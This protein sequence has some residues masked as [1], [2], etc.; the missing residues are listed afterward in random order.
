MA[1]KTRGARPRNSR[2]MV[3]WKIL[4]MRRKE[5]VKMIVEK[6]V[7]VKLDDAERR[8]LTEKVK[9]FIEGCLCEGI[10]CSGIVC[11]SECPLYNLDEQA[12]ALRRS[13]L[14]FINGAD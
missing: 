8:I 11:S 4:E 10:D 14:N 13:V 3:R 5:K 1:H 7:K 6:I 2:K 12:Q 9:E